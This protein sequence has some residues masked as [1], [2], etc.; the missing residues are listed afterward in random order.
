MRCWIVEF[1]AFIF[2]RFLPKRLAFTQLFYVWMRTH[3]FSKLLKQFCFR[4]LFGFGHFIQYS[5]INFPVFGDRISKRKICKH[6][7]RHTNQKTNYHKNNCV[8]PNNSNQISKGIFIIKR[9]ALV[10]P[11]IFQKKEK[12]IITWNKK[13]LAMKTYHAENWSLK[14]VLPAAVVKYL[15]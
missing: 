7:Q 11:R 8:R 2:S 10:L 13:I 9:Q 4:L 3:Q 15:K 1:V 14:A 5:K 6:Q 12:N